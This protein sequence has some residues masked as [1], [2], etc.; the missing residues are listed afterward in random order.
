MNNR[1][2][3][4]LGFF[5]D[6]FSAAYILLRRSRPAG[7]SVRQLGIE[8]N[9]ALMQFNFASPPRSFIFRHLFTPSKP[10]RLRRQRSLIGRQPRKKHLQRN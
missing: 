4:T 7:R 6:F 9:H 8:A 10:A 5:L 1:I 2:A 3:G